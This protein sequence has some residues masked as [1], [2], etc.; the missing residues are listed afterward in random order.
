MKKIE[1][2][3]AVVKK[4]PVVKASVRAGSRISDRRIKRDIRPLSAAV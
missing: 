2:K 3:K 1:K 4:H